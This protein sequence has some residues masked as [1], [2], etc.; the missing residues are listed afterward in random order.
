[1]DNVGIL[2]FCHVGL[3]DTQKKTPK[4]G[5][6]QGVGWGGDQRFSLSLVNLVVAIIWVRIVKKLFLFSGLRRVCSSS[7]V[8]TI[9]GRI[10]GFEPELMRPRPDVLPM[11]Y[12]HP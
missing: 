7:Q 5:G 10:P 9:F 8:F 1:M 4:K 6:K 11:S 12:T 3:Q 2:H